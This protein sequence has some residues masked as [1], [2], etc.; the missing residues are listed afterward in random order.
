MMIH[1]EFQNMKFN[2]ETYR[3]CLRSEGKA[4]IEF[5]YKP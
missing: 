4:I 1:R 2:R 5:T 3:Q